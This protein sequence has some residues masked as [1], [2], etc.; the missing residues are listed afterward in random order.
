VPEYAGTRA[1]ELA[2]GDLRVDV[3]HRD[4]LAWP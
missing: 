1:A 2:D 4:L 3:D